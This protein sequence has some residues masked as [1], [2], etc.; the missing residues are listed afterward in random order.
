MEFRSKSLALAIERERQP[1]DLVVLNGEYYEGSSI[2]FYIQPKVYLLNGRMTGL[3]FGSRYPDAPPLFIGD[4]EIQEWWAGDR[5]V[6]LFTQGAKRDRLERQ[7]RRERMYLIAA[8]GG[9][10]V[11]SNRP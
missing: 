11:F 7:L 2:G 4:C 6:F 3:E 5:R 1:G 8:S 9:K 10:F